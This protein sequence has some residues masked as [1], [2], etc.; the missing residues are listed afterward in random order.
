MVS[1][2]FRSLSIYICVWPCLGSVI[3]LPSE[4]GNGEEVVERGGHTY[5]HVDIYIG[6]Y[7]ITFSLYDFSLSVCLPGRWE[8][9]GRRRRIGGSLSFDTSVGCESPPSR[10]THSCS[11]QSLAGFCCAPRPIYIFFCVTFFSF[12]FL[13]SPFLS[14]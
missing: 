14:G 9:G 6:G 2:A 4:G 5:R 10:T 8:E 13:L 7:M 12:L 1:K 11:S 3:F